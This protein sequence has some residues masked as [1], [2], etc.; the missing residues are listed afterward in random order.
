MDFSPGAWK[1]QVPS[2]EA[3]AAPGPPTLRTHS[4]VW[5]RHYKIVGAWDHSL[6]GGLPGL[7]QEQ[8]SLSKG[9]ILAAS[10]GIHRLANCIE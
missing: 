7:R 10:A 1:G 6:D 2:S 5:P 8:G 4:F 3:E 9:L